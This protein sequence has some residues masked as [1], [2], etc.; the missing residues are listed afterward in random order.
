MA[1]KL[2]R[3]RKRAECGWAGLGMDLS[4]AVVFVLEQGRSDDADDESVL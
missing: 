1:V 2:E 4:F 3:M